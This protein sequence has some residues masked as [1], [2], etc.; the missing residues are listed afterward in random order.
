MTGSSENRYRQ[1][2]GKN[3]IMQRY[4]MCRLIAK[5]NGKKRKVSRF[6]NCYFCAIRYY[7][8]VL[9]IP[10]WIF[11]SFFYQFAAVECANNRW[12]TAHLQMK[13]FGINVV[14]RGL[15][16]FPRGRLLFVCCSCVYH[17]AKKE[18]RV[19]LHV[20]S[21][22]LMSTRCEQTALLMR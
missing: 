10:L 5:K 20:N 17:S 12:Q 21:F 1:K 9:L 3:P 8:L 14:D 18:D 7:W 4:N 19:G 13:A 6:Y 15:L 22:V 16:S 2:M 11:Y